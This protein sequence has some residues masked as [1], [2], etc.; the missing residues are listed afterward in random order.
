[1]VELEQLTVVMG[2]TLATW[3]SVTARGDPP[4]S[5]LVSPPVVTA[6]TT[7]VL[8]TLGWLLIEAPGGTALRFIERVDSSV[9]VAWPF[10]VALMLRPDATRGGLAV[11][12]IVNVE[13]RRE[14]AR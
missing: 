14:T 2:V 12:G 10:V 6:N 4:L 7:V 5:I 1:M 9:R 8:A 3:P 11:V 13:S